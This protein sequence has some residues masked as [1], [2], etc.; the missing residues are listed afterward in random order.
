[1]EIGTSTFSHKMMYDHDI[2]E[3]NFG[4]VKLFDL[5]NYPHT[6]IPSKV[7]KAS[8]HKLSNLVKREI[9]GIRDQ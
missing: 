5:T 8:L 6:I 9:I 2:M 3:G 4:K 1:M 7:D